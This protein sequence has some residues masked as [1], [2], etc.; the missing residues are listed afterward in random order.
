MMLSKERQDK[1]IEILREKDKV[2]F[3]ELSRVLQTSYAT[4][5]RDCEQLESLNLLTRISK[6]V[7]LNE[8]KYDIDIEYRQIKN[9]S[10]KRKIAKRASKYLKKNSFIFLDAGTTVNELIPYLKGLNIVVVT[11]GTMHLKKLMDNR[12]ETI[13]LGGRVK[14]KTRSIVSPEAIKQ[15]KRYRF[16]ACFMGTNA[17]S[18]ELGYMTPDTDEAE[19]KRS[20]IESSKQAFVLAEKSK[21]N[22]ISNVRFAEFDKCVYIGEDDD[23][24][25]NA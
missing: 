6:G 19:I 12:V 17:F 25:S 18:N 9:V 15:I 23:L 4:V 14:D 13:V 2:S 8:K 5:R 21:F 11:N 22:K 7:E 10:I 16:D 24:Y 1:I 20:V 3:E